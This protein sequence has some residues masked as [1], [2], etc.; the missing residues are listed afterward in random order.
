VTSAALDR[1]APGTT[2]TAAAVQIRGLRKEYGSRVAVAGLDLDVAPGEVFG[3]LGPNGAGKTTTVKI[4]TG[5]V[6]PTSG[7]A[8]I[9]GMEST[10]PE[11]RRRVGYLPELFRFPAWLTGEQLLDFHGRLIGLSAQERRD[12]I[13]VVL[14][15]VGLG[16]RGRDRIRSY[17]KGMTQR[18]GLAQALLGDPLL[19]LLDEPTS[20][21]DPV[22]RR[23]V[24]D[25]IR[26]LRDDGITV[27]LNSHMLAEVEQVC[28]RVAVVDRGH[29]VFA[30][31]LDEL[32]T[33]PSVRVVVSDI[34]ERLLDVL[35]R[36][37]EVERLDPQTIRITLRAG[38]DAAQVAATVVGGGWR[39][40]ALLPSAESLEDA[41]LR[42]IRDGA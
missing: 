1:R 13:P 32:A 35:H 25:L 31:R 26:S 21:L 4:L 42:L 7:S 39:L 33:E 5:L 29:V 17:S 36:H 19:V 14:D 27:F 23:D 41:F 2:D 18:I 11:A 34:D 28:D 10:R 38:Q 3:L 16:G 30:G 24:R 22:G 8:R 15:R 37:G 12:A 20:A 9:F 6:Q 40:Q